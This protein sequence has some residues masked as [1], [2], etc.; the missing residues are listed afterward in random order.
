MP[1]TLVSSHICLA[2]PVV[3]AP[4]RSCRARTS[5]C[6]YSRSMASAASTDAAPSSVPEI[7]APSPS[8]V[9]VGGW[10]G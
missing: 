7:V 2:R 6:S 5:V 3:V 1:L 10:V 8:F 9:Q 4:V